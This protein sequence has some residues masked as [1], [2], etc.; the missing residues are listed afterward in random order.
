MLVK[1][2]F[3][4]K[5]LKYVLLV[6]LS[7]C[8]EDAPLDSLSPE[9]PYA[10][11]IDE[12]FWITFWIAVVIFVIVQGAL[13]LSVFVYKEKPDSPEP[14][15]IHGN[16][17]LEILWTVIP[18][19]ILAAIAVP[20]V[21]TIFDLAR[22]PEN[23][24]KIEVI[25]H[26]WWFEYKYPD[27]GITTANVLVIPADRPV[28]LEMWSNDVLHNYWVPK[29]NGKRYLVPGQTTYLN[30]HADS[31]SEFWAQCGEYC[32]LSHSKMRGRV[33]SLSQ[34]DFDAW[35][36]NEQRDATAFSTDDLSLAAEG[37]QVYLNA[38]CTQC[39]VINGVW[40]VQGDRIAPN[41]THFANRNVFAGAALK[42]NP[43]NLT[44]WLANPAEIKPGTFMPNLELTE[45]EINAL[46]AYLET[47]K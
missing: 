44:K 39:H 20:T 27:Y 15:Q 26:Q 40:D 25:G 9:G 41:L 33:L 22:E 31:P 10:R 2:I 24:L 35:V 1:K 17:K 11:S 4:L 5:N 8:I 18:V 16:T 23:A 32:E 29:L 34:S 28:R 14:K 37:Q 19:L 47:L 3:R 45:S 12:L 36:K 6:F 13:L 7:A 21:R 38:G 43:E 42:N 30:L 46:I